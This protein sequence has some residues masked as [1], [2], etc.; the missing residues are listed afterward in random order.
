MVSLM[1]IDPK[2]VRPQGRKQT[3]SLILKD[4]LEEESEVL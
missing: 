3:R 1:V 2:Y 4:L